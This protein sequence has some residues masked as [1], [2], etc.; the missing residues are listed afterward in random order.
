VEVFVEKLRNIG[1]G[2]GQIRA[3]IIVTIVAGMTLGFASGIAVVEMAQRSRPVLS[4]PGLAAKRAVPSI[5]TSEILAAT[6]EPVHFLFLA[7]TSL[8]ILAAVIDFAGRVLCLAV[9]SNCRGASHLQASLALVGINLLFGAWSVASEIGIVG[10]PPIIAS[11][12][13]GMLSIVAS[14]LFMIF[15]GLLAEYIR[16]DDLGQRARSI[17]N[18]SIVLAVSGIVGV[19]FTLFAT[20]IFPTF[21][22]LGLLGML[23]LVVLAIVL[24]VRYLRLLSDLRKSLFA[25]ADALE[26]SESDAVE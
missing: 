20:I 24:L 16:R 10:K 14:I 12:L 22:I 17:L 4:Q 2:L 7:G 9:P 25:F 15:L 26:R 19:F 3:A 23:A 13:T 1:M 21:L 5:K 8:A 18:F 11:M 6:S